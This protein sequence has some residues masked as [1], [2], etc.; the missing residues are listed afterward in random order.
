MEDSSNKVTKWC[1]GC[2]TPR[3]LLDNA[4]QCCDDKKEA[5]IVMLDDKDECHM[6]ATQNIS[7]SEL[8]RVAVELMKLAQSYLIQESEDDEND[9]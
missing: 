6:W 3:N 5:V 9:Y 4:M 7:K 1:F 8:C 2:R